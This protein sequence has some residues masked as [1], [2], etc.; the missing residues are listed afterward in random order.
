MQSND[1]YPCAEGLERTAVCMFNRSGY[2]EIVATGARSEIEVFSCVDPVS[3]IGVISRWFQYEGFAFKSY[4]TPEET[5][6]VR[7]GAS[8]YSVHFSRIQIAPK[9]IRHAANKG[10]FSSVCDPTW[11]K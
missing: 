8:S 11:I 1:A 6:K 5:G 9:R 10:C 7:R 2:V 3:P 4:E